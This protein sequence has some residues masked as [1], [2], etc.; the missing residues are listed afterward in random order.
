[1]LARLKFD[2]PPD[3]IEVLIVLARTPAEE[4]RHL[5]PLRRDGSRQSDAAA[6][7]TRVH[8]ADDLP[9]GQSLAPGDLDGRCSYLRAS[10]I[11]TNFNA[12]EFMQ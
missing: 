12:A 7:A 1:V 9:R 10:A 2:F 6:N 3:E 4:L 8:L 5:E 11:G